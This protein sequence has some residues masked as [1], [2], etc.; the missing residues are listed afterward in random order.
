MMAAELLGH[1]LMINQAQAAGFNS[2]P[3]FDLPGTVASNFPTEYGGLIQPASADLPAGLFEDT[4]RLA[5]VA[6]GQ[7]DVRATPLQM[8]LLIAGVAN[9][10]VIPTPHVLDQIFD[11]DGGVITTNEPEAWRQALRPESARDIMAALEEAATRGGAS[12]AAM[13]GFTIGG[14]TGT[15]QI[16]ADTP[17]SHAWIVA[18]GGRPG[19]EPEL[20]VAVLVEAQE[21]TD[22]TGGGVAGPVAQAIFRE[23]FQDVSG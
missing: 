21:G 3:P 22:Q 23:Y 1:E 9:D 14:K 15:A 16:D 19:E 20:A 10:G 6:I 13:E 11:A 7:N 12:S 17:Q 2:A 4:P 5:Q 8:A 18:F